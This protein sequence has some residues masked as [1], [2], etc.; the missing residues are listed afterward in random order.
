[1]AD[2]SPG[3]RIE[4]DGHAYHVIPAQIRNPSGQWVTTAS[5]L[6]AYISVPDQLLTKAEIIR[7]ICAAVGDAM[8]VRLV[9]VS[10]LG[11]GAQP[12]AGRRASASP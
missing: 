3:F 12:S 1:M 9:D 6:D 2:R 7:A 11:T 8:N 10:R 5:I 4:Q